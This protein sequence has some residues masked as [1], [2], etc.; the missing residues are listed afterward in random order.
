MLDFERTMTPF[1]AIDSSSVANDDVSRASCGQHRRLHRPT[2]IRVRPTHPMQPSIDRL[3][4]AVSFAPIFRRLSRALQIRNSPNLQAIR[5]ICNRT[6]RMRMRDAGPIPADT[7]S[8]TVISLRPSHERVA[9]G[10]ASSF[11]SS[12]ATGKQNHQHPVRAPWHQE[13]KT[14]SNF[15]NVIRDYGK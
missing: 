10:H 9:R 14:K 12:M 6:L 13:P 1:P 8:T 4:V 3:S 5:S 7:G 11:R 2:T 15:A